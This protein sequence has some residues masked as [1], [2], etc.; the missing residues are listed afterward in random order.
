[1]ANW[2]L[3]TNTARNSGT[4][5]TQARLDQKVFEFA[6]GSWLGAAAVIVRLY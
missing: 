2:P 6:P 4:T 1:M 3:I 5:L